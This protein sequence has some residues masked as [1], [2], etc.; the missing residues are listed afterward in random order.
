MV[1]SSAEAGSQFQALVHALDKAAAIFNNHHGLRI[2]IL[3][4]MDISAA[5][6]PQDGSF[7]LQC[8]EKNVDFRVSTVGTTWGEIIESWQLR[9]SEDAPAEPTPGPSVP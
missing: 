1:E 5:R 9:S 3:D 6:R 8:G 7:D 4:T 2:K